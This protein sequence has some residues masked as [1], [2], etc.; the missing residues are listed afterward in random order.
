M[1]G[2]Q[3]PAFVTTPLLFAKKS[4]FWPVIDC[5]DTVHQAAYVGNVA[6]M[7]VC[8][9]N[10]LIRDEKNILGGNAFFAADDTPT[11]TMFAINAPIATAC[12]LSA[13]GYKFPLWLVMFG[14]YIIFAL[15]W[16]FSY[17]RKLN[18]PYGTGS[19]LQ[20]GVSYTFKYEKA[21][22]MFRYTPLYQYN[23]SIERS[24][25][26]YRKIC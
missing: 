8:A 17:V 18:F 16:V 13:D 3:D 4:G 23:E 2:E 6:W 22:S 25:K 24:V 9:E 7:F 19:F 11:K 10:A 14:I 1:Y 26:F 12:N 15:L 5:K 20:L 21:K